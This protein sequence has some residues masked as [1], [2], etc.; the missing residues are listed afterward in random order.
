MF[1]VIFDKLKCVPPHDILHMSIKK[2][3]PKGDGADF[4][5]VFP[6]R[7]TGYP[8]KRETQ[9]LFGLGGCMAKPSVR[10]HRFACQLKCRADVVV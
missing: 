6:D 2:N 9:G 3:M 7:E 8:G 1:R 10:E 4:P 5:L